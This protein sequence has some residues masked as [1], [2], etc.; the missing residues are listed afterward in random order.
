MQ[1]NKTKRILASSTAG[2]YERG[3]SLV[4]ILVSAA[5]ISVVL[6]AISGIASSS[7]SISHRTVDTYNA[8]LLLEEGAEA[9]RTYRDNAWSNISALSSGTNYCPT[10]AT[11][12]NSWSFPAS[13]TCSKVN[14]IFT[15]SLTVS[16]VN[17]SSTSSNIIS[18]GGTV[19]SGTELITVTVSWLEGNLT[20]TKTLQF[21]LSNILS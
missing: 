13:S 4:E 9:V 20:A 15:R 3:F 12:T 21:Y 11:S 19:D 7:V 18:S 14:S 1:K 17:R 2:A 5:I 6:L 8:T 10:F 16:A